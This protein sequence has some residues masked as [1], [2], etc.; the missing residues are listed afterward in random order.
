MTLY[1][2]SSAMLKRYVDEPDSPLADRLLAADPV[3]VTSRLT[4]LEV[5]HNLARLVATEKLEAVRRR[6]LSD[7]EAFAIVALD[8]I[9]CREAAIVAE[10]TLCR[11]LDALHLASARRIGPAVTVLTFDLRQARVARSLGLEVVGAQA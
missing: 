8:A 5:R 11:S 10:R 1:V 2:D 6:F 4:E 3:L 7:L 9:I